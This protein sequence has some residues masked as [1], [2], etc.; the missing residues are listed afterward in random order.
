[1]KPRLKKH[2]LVISQCF[3]PEQFRI[4]DICKE[5]V[6]R[7]YKVTVLTSIPN[8]PE[9]KFYQGYGYFKKRKEKYKGINIIRVPVIPRGNN[10]FT[11]IL[12]YISFVIS[13]ILWGLF[14][15]I[16][17]D[18][19]FMNETSPIFQ[20]LPGVFY[21]KKNKIPGYI[22]VQDLWPDTLEALTNF[23]HPL[24]IKFVDLIVDYVYSSCDKIFTTS[25]SFVD[26]I[27][28]RGVEKE[29]LE[30]LPQYAEEFYKP[31]QISEKEEINKDKFNITFAGNIGYAQGLDIL[32]D[33]TSKL[34]KQNL[35]KKVVFNIIG[36]GRY[37]EEL[38]TEV[39]NNNL[40]QTFN[41][42]DRKPAK[43][44]P[45]YMAV[46]DA[47]LLTL[48]DNSLF[49]MSV[50][51]K[52]QS[53]MACGVPV[54]AAVNGE[55]RKIIKE[56]EAGLC[57]ETGDDEELANN[58][59]QLLN[60]NKKELKKMGDN[61]RNYYEDNFDKETLLDQLDKYFS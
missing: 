8:Y 14:T 20:A 29:K 60:K 56:A 5:W 59:I 12:N 51:A 10:S 6:K 9:G 61:S 34:K 7:G 55:S 24:I 49:N 26:S 33:V 52:L 53:Y 32:L 58:I 54:I 13:G 38:I 16:K 11:L 25:R 30:Y 19:V 31:I 45:E 41:F 44:I 23:D 50:P 35:E 2:I 36:D 42:I 4:N 28:K 1:M 37:K 22:Y 46:S 47:A 15:S 18:Y 48:T 40:N 17:A 57:S 3:Y 43:E 39:E 21:A 27:A